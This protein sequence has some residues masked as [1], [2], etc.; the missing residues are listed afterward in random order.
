M[1]QILLETVQWHMEKVDVI[2]NI[3]HGFT[4]GFSGLV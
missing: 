1:E 3:H 2:D 4:K